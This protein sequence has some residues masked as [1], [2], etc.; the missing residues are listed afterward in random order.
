M[1]LRIILTLVVSLG[2]LWVSEEFPVYAFFEPQSTGWMLWMS[3]AKDFIQPFAFYFFISLSEKW[4]KQWQVRAALAFGIPT[5]MEVGQFFYPAFF[6]R[7]HT[8]FFGSFDWFDLVMYALGVGLAALVEQKI[9]IHRSFWKQG[10]P[11]A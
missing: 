11:S 2:L 7:S 6:Y 5:L 3:Y 8:F 9:L 10:S 4:L 1:I